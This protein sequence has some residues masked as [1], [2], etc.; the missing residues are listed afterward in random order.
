VLPRGCPCQAA[1]RPP[2]RQDQLGTPASQLARRCVGLT[3][4]QAVPISPGRGGPD[5]A[6][7]CWLGGGYSPSSFRSYL[8]FSASV[9]WSGTGV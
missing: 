7:A 5:L 8:T 9:C 4:S 3:R 6:R 2:S 1:T